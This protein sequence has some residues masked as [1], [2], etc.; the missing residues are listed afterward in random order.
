MKYFLENRIS[1]FM[2]FAGLFIF[3]IISLGRIPVSLMPQTAYPA[4]SVIIEYPGISPD[5]IETLISKPVEKIVKTITGIEKIESV[6]EEGKSRINISFKLGTDIKVAA[7]KVREKIGLIKDYFPEEVQEPVVVRYDPSDR[8]VLIATIDKKGLSQIKIREFAERNI[9]PVLQRIEGISEINIAGGLQREIHIDIDRGK[10]DSRSL[11]FGEIYSAVQ[12]NNISLPGGLLRS[13]EKEFI[14]YSAM[15]YK[16]ISDIRDTPIMQAARGS[17]VKLYDFADV[18]ESCRE[19]E[20][21]ARYNGQEMVTLYI[22]KAGDANTL[23]VCNNAKKIFNRIQDCGINVIYDQGKY[24]NVAINNVVSS[25]IWGGLIVIFVLYVFIRR[26]DIVLTIGLSIPVAII[27]VFACMYFIKIGIDV[28]SLSGLA[29]GAGMIVDNGIVITESIFG[30]KEIN[31]HTISNGVSKVRNAIISSTLTTIVVFMP[32]AFGNILT[33]RMYGSLAFTVSSALLISL[34]IAIILIPAVFLSFSRIRNRSNNIGKKIKVHLYT[35]GFFSKA[36]QSEKILLNK[37]SNII[38]YTFARRKTVIGILVVLI[39]IALILLTLLKSEFIDPAGTGEFYVYLEFPTGTSLN[40]TDR[41]V[42]KAESLIQ[43]MNITEKISTKVEKWRGTLTVKLLD[44]ISS[45]EKQNAAKTRLKEDVQHHIKEYGGFVF[46]TEADETSARELT[47]T[48]TGNDNNILR[49]LAAQCASRVKTV[50]KIEDCVLR[51]RE[52]KPEYRLTIDRHKSTASFLS[53]QEITN[54]FRNAVFGPVIT[55]FIDNDRE[56]DVRM[57]YLPEQRSSIEEILNYSIMNSEGSLIPVKEIVRLNEGVG[58]TKI[59]RHN[60]CRCVSITA[61]IGDLSYKSA[62]LQIDSVLKGIKFPDEY[63]YIY[64]ETVQ[65]IEDNKKNMMV[66]IILA[67]LFIY[68]I[69]A[70][71]FESFVLPLIIITTVPMAII[72]VIIMLFITSSTM[73]ISVYIGLIVLTGIVVNNGII[74]VDSVNAMFR[75]NLIKEENIHSIIKSVCVERF[76]PVMITTVTTILGLIPMLLKSGEGSNLWS[77]LSLTVI[78]G[79][80]FSTVLTLIIIP[81]FCYYIFRLKIKK[82]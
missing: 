36:D 66:S 65:K 68:M 60:G 49:E 10:F 51:F 8:P 56:V 34:A 18:L 40:T 67:I 22:H 3:G 41:A 58:P 70:S 29:L 42:K 9:K 45:K 33:R 14:V 44:S 73:N 80:L 79:L 63:S 35:K 59:W 64:D 39:F 61:R 82:I 23:D 62:A 20:D 72:G 12:N 5:K 32:I 54:F 17:L 24:I 69:M 13:S 50:P 7:L 37:F 48:F 15:R 57:K 6:S 28:M 74:L 11:A 46:L 81:I 16:D 27:I 55:K 77:P 30:N 19:R 75:E 1:A 31:F 78:S 4:I 43:S 21:I 47:I 76:R 25:C 38:D 52:G 71:L 26:F 53:V 2:L